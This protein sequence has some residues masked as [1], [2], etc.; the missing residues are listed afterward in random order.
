MALFYNSLL[1]IIN[2]VL[3]IGLVETKNGVATNII[4]FRKI[5]GKT[6]KPYLIYENMIG[7]GVCLMFMQIKHVTRSTMN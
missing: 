6:I 1:S 3:K 2:E 4:W 7:L 5:L